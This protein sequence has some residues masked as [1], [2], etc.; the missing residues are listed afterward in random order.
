MYFLN[1]LQNS[2]LMAINKGTVIK[3]LKS[4]YGSFTPKETRVGIGLA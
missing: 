3:I 2:I 1:S 4:E